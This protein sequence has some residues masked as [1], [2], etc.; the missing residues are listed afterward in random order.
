MTENIAGYI[1]TA[2]DRLRRLRNADINPST[3]MY[4][5]LAQEAI[6]NTL[7]AIAMILDGQESPAVP[8]LPKGYDIQTQQAPEGQ[9]KWRYVVTGPLFAHASRYRWDTSEGALSAGIT[10]ARDQESHRAGYNTALADAAREAQA[11]NEPVDI[12][13]R[14]S[15]ARHAA[16]GN[17]G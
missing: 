2:Q 5:A 7:T 4:A 6:A 3:Q 17:G 14:N 11:L 9:H 1:A 10:H 12:T 8:G 16:Y 15:E 13:H